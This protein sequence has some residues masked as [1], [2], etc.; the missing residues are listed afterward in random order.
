MPE[1][2]ME[3]RKILEVVV[4]EIFTVVAIIEMSEEGRERA[5]RSVSE[6]L[7]PQLHF[8]EKLRIQIPVRIRVILTALLGRTA[9]S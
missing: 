3:Q 5:R 2:D 7:N 4:L 9:T 6:F 1:A 8:K